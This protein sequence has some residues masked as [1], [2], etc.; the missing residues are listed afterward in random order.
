MTK[1]NYK[2]AVRIAEN[3][4]AIRTNT[5]RRAEAFGIER[6]RENIARDVGLYGLP[7]KDAPDALREMLLAAAEDELEKV[8]HEQSAQA[9]GDR[10]AETDTPS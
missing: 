9:S 4:A 3:L 1:T 6:A 5:L 2:L 10:E 7:D 8:A